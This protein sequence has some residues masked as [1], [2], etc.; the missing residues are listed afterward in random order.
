MPHRAGLPAPRSETQRGCQEGR[1]QAREGAREETREG[2]GKGW[3]KWEPRKEEEGERRDRQKASL[4]HWTRALVRTARDSGLRISKFH[5]SLLSICQA[6]ASPAPAV[7]GAATVKGARATSLANKVKSKPCRSHLPEG[8]STSSP[9]AL[10]H[11]SPSPAG[12]GRAGDSGA[13]GWGAGS[14]T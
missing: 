9:A 5:H 6:T 2:R 8:E 4:A 14:C 12:P 7:K 1:R 10:P 11:P 3:Q 13:E